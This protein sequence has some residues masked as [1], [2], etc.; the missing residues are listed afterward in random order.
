M[1]RFR[2]SVRFAN[3]FVTSNFNSLNSRCSS[4]DE[5]TTPSDRIIPSVLHIEDI[6]NR[7]APQL[8]RFFKR[9][10]GHDDA[11]DLVNDSFVRFVSAEATGN[12]GVDCPEAY[13]NRIALNLLR[14]RARSALNR[15]LA[16]HIPVDDVALPDCDPVARF[17]ARDKLNRLQQALLRLKPKT[18]AI[19]LAH[20]IDGLSYKEIA[21]R[22]GLSV[23]GVEWH[24][25]KAID[26]LDR[27]LKD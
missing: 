5:C 21:E 23:K 24:M 13:L 27:A 6:Y 4:D 14:D 3:K 20:R 8:R 7:N 16:R 19:F 9:R 25:T 1:D 18:R 22:H 17:E 10:A 26:H 11:D 15:S 12:R 2:H